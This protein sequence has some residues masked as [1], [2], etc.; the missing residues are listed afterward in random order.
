[1]WPVPHVS[2][3]GV[4]IHSIEKLPILEQVLK[5]ALPSYTFDSVSP[6]PSRL[7]H[8]TGSSSEFRGVLRYF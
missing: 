1:M 5:P 6:L 3:I 7:L 4:A 2:D 8:F